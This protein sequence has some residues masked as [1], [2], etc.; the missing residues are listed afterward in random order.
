MPTQLTT[1]VVGNAPVSG[2]SVAADVNDAG[3]VVGNEDIAFPFV[4]RP[5]TPNGT[6]GS[7]TRLQTLFTPNIG[8]GAAT[9]V[10]N[11][12]DV[13]GF[14][15]TVDANG[16]DVRHAVL[17]QAG[18]GAPIDLGTLQPNPSAPGT[19]LG[20][21]RALGINDSGVITGVS[22]SPTGTHAFLFDPAV[23]AMTDLG[24]LVPAPGMG[25]SQGNAIDSNGSVVGTSDALD[26][27]GNT[28]S[29]AFLFASGASMTDL[30][31]LFP[32]PAVP[33]AF[34]GN[35]SAISIS[36]A[37]QIVGDSDTPPL[38]SSSTGAFF[39][40]GAAP[41]PM[42]AAQMTVFDC[43][44]NSDVVG[45]FTA[46]GSLAFRWTPGGAPID[47]S[48]VFAGHTIINALAINN[49][50]QIAAL[51]SDGTNTTAV[52]LTP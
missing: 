40:S 17:W 18:G 49:H 6:V 41:T 12:G 50:G 21:S 28:V 20:N 52:L 39:S 24:T 2:E 22:D 47:L 7:S 8:E 35:S 15:D 37:G 33:G 4:W 1:T 14:S 25:A 48:G 19:F 36:D 5:N 27:Q 3:V 9:A 26:S 16:N 32:D 10:N 42:F 29:R 11:Q 13:V 43:N 31:T 46:S 23:S 34:S 51:A 44:N 30:G 45:A 38:P